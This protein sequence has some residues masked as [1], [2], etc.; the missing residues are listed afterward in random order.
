[1]FIFLL[2]LSSA[3]LNSRLLF[4]RNDYTVIKLGCYDFFGFVECPSDHTIL[5]GA[6]V[7]LIEYDMFM[8][9]DILATDQIQVINGTNRG[10]FQFHACVDEQFSYIAKNAEIFY[11]FLD[12]CKQHDNYRFANVN[13]TEPEQEFILDWSHEV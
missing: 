3:F 12:V 8:Y 13:V 11:E 1:M 2:E 10:K 7:R 6:R 4:F 5:D 9:N